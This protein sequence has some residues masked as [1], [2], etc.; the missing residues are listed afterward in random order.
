MRVTLAGILTRA[1]VRC[2]SRVALRVGDASWTYGDLD[3]KSAALASGFTELGISKGDFVALYLKN[4]AEYVIADLALLKIG[5]VKVP[6]NE[7][8]SVDDVTYILDD[9]GATTLV[10]HQS[11]LIGLGPAPSRRTALSHIV[12][13]AEEGCEV[14]K[15]A[16]HWWDDLLADETFAAV[17]SSPED[18]AMI[19]YTGGTTGTPKGVVQNQASLGVNLF[20]H[21]VAGEVSA[22]DVMLLST[23]LPHSAGYHLQACLLQ[24][25]QVILQSRFDPATF[26]AVVEERKVTWTFMVPTMIYRL[27][28][29]GGAPVRDHSSLRSIVYGAAPMSGAQLHRAIEKFGLCFIQLY[30]QTECPNYITALTKDDHSNP[31]LH[32]S[33]GKAVPFVEVATTADDRRGLGEVVVRSPYLLTEYFKNADATRST[34]RQGWLHTG[35]IGYIDDDGYLFLKD[36]AK[37]MIISGGMNVYTSE[38][39][40]ALKRHPAVADAGVIGL[41]HSDWGEQVHAVVEIRRDAEVTKNALI[42]WCRGKLSRY[43]VP[44]SMEFRAAL[45]LTAYGKVDKKALRNER[46]GE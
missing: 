2:R 39:E 12:C 21:I 33:C 45:P 9:T 28:D 23:P 27:L 35:D 11:L 26:H 15:P 31:E 5:A 7:Y 6:L 14:P 18:I 25:G 4:C 10:A 41:P 17:E 40:Q 46:A 24:G 3:A 22:S 20:A 32:E 30:G 16:H 34:L 8:Q 29:Y 44:K 36:R 1:I 13:V 37:D 19:T 43:K 38:V 42:D